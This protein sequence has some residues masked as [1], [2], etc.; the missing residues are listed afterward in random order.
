[1]KKQHL[2][3]GIL[4]INEEESLVREEKEIFLR[5]K[6]LTSKEEKNIKEIFLKTKF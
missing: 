1:M 2:L 3:V 4:L 5:K 6:A